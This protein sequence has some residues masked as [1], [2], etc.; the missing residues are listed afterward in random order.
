MSSGLLDHK[1][2]TASWGKTLHH[3][4]LLPLTL[5]SLSCHPSGKTFTHP[6]DTFWESYMRWFH[7]PIGSE[8][9]L[10]FSWILLCHLMHENE[11]VHD[12]KWWLQVSRNWKN[13]QCS[14]LKNPKNKKMQTKSRQDT[15]DYTNL[16]TNQHLSNFS[17]FLNKFVL[18]EV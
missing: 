15:L 16:S 10:V 6:W 12:R 9:S 4:H 11:P 14:W 18:L 5:Q 17:V 8:F 13:V 1:S 3:Q 2:W 7:I